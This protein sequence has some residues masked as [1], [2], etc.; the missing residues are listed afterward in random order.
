VKIAAFRGA[1]GQA[2]KLETAIPRKKCGV[3]D[4]WLRNTLLVVN[5]AYAFDIDV[6]RPFI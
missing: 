1:G 4:Q 5:A 6:P 3:G 2:D